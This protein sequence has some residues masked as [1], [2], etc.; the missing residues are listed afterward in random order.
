[1]RLVVGVASHWL[2][3]W[4]EIFKPITERRKRCY[5]RCCVR[6]CFASGNK[7]SEN[8]G[9][10]LQTI[11]QR[12]VDALQ[13]CPMKQLFFLESVNFL[14]A[15]ACFIRTVPERMQAME[16]MPSRIEES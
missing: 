8:D 6:T 15:S 1:M 9:Y 7:T 13:S 3:N 5:V 10:F 14:T 2:K 16:R 12:R 4:R 11:F